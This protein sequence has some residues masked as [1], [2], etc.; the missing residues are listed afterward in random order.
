[1]TFEKSP[2]QKQNEPNELIVNQAD[3]ITIREE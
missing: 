1:M 3:V 2:K